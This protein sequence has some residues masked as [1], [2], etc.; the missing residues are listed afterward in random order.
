MCTVHVCGG[1]VLTWQGLA[2]RD[3]DLENTANALIFPALNQEFV[4]FIAHVHVLLVPQV[5]IRNSWPICCLRE[6]R[7]PTSPL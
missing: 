5:C 6:Q 7:V 3:A 2:R 1:S 4:H